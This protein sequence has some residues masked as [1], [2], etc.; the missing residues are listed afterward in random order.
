MS[1]GTSPF[2]VTP[3]GA[4]EDSIQ[5]LLELVSILGA[6]N[7]SVGT[8]RADSITIG[9][10]LLPEFFVNI[11]NNAV[12]NSA[13]SADIIY[14][15]LDEIL[16]T[17]V[18]NVW[19]LYVAI[20]NE[21]AQ[22]TGYPTVLWDAAITD[23]AITGNAVT[24][25]ILRTV[26]IIDAMVANGLVESRYTGVAALSELMAIAGAA[27]IVADGNITDAAVI[28]ELL[29]ESTARIAALLDSVIAQADA[30]GLAI[31]TVQLRDDMAVDGNVLTQALFYG[32]LEERLDFSV[33]LA[34]DGLTYLGI[35][36]NATNKAITEYQPYD[37]NSLAIMDGA[38]YGAN[39]A[40]L[41]RLEGDTDDAVNIDAYARTALTRI[42]D[43]R[44]AQVD[45]AY[46]G[47]S[48]DGVI[49]LK[50]ITTSATGAKTSRVYQLNL[51]NA[52]ANRS[53]RIKLGKGIKSV[54]W[55]FELSN[56]LGA[57]FTIDVIELRALALSRRI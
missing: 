34:L 33:S 47:Y 26:A 3:F 50:A 52:D 19:A 13:I 5:N 42:A 10:V 43:G 22:T 21:I 25:D 1:Y 38:L 55:A 44:M 54:Y 29:A 24:A 16:A 31:V 40:G 17:D 35:C 53:G 57:D 37:F 20:V 49:Q 23:T 56:S 18:H 6:Q 30:L 15:V 51:Q 36:M 9:S 2:G 14:S 4:E 39:D 41:F 7:I 8:N 28:S 48:S 45:S 32:L 11:V 27:V 46:L 12:W